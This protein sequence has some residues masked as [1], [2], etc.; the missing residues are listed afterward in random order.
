MKII[1]I[2]FVIVI[3]VAIVV[4]VFRDVDNGTEPKTEE[5]VSVMQDEDR[6]EFASLSP[7]FRFSA[8]L[9]YDDWQIRFVPEIEAI[10]VGG[11]IFIRHFK[12][13][14]FLT[15]STVTI[16][17]REATTVH[18]HAAVR[19]EIEK[20]PGVPDFLHQPAWRNT[21]HDVLDIRFS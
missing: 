8:K 11:R 14:D 5:S 13:S 10:D 15:L 20:K 6:F 1:G 17:S 21:R 3:A 2:I 16:H 9:P 12:A 19:Y 4:V 7:I 18:D